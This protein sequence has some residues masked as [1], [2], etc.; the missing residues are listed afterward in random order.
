M[1][2]LAAYVAG[3]ALV[4]GRIPAR[5]TVKTLDQGLAWVAQLA[6]FVML[7][8]LVLASQLGGAALEWPTCRAASRSSAS[9]FFAALVSTVLQGTTVKPLA[10]RLGSMER[11]PAHRAEPSGYGRAGAVP[12]LE[13]SARRHGTRRARQPDRRRARR[14]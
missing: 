3:P 1:G 9:S 4:G 5:R 10:R 13:A 8:L 6:M 14:G 12:D 11:A 2:R 7:G